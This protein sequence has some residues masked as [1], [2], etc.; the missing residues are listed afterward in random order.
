MPVI[1]E[2]N[3][4]SRLDTNDD[5]DDTE[6]REEQGLFELDN[7]NTNVTIPSTEND[8]QNTT[9]TQADNANQV[10]PG[11]FYVQSSVGDKW[12]LT[13]PIWHMLPRDERRAIATK[14]GMKSIGE[15][16][17]YMSL[18][19]AVDESEVVVGGQ[20]SGVMSTHSVEVFR[21]VDEVEDLTSRMEGVSVRESAGVAGATAE[22]HPPFV[23]DI[24]EGND[25]SSV[26]SSEDDNK[27]TAN[28]QPQPEE[29]DLES[30]LEH[31][32]LAGL[33]C[34]LPDEILHKCFSFLPVDDYSPLALVSP[35]WSRFTRC[36]SLYKTLCE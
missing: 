16:E 34:G 23:E 26:S 20:K 24:A 13:W 10:D 15:F 32:K 19:R 30:H 33:P 11:P 5:D 22:W 21:D 8:L 27:P 25:D 36:E 9:N 28:E 3:R 29:V 14:H 4:P 35:H 1:P 7:D 2:N 17:E 31:I 12:E 6:D 18:T